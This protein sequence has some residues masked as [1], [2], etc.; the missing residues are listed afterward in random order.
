MLRKLAFTSLL[1]AGL[2]AVTAEDG[3]AQEKHPA[4]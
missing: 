2:L 1:V 3:V 4:A